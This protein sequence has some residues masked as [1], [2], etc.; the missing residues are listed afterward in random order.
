M[1]FSV[2]VRLSHTLQVIKQH[3]F[4]LCSDVQT[5]DR[6]FFF[7]IVREN[8]RFTARH[9]LNVADSSVKLEDLFASKQQMVK[10]PKAPKFL[11]LYLKR[12][13]LESENDTDH[14]TG[15]IH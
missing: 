2:H 11:Y 6:D 9:K 12:V 14:M 15:V 8:K 3:S 7:T 10:E 13:I 5:F 4:L 1:V